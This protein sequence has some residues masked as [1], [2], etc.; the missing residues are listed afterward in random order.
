MEDRIEQIPQADWVDQDLLT[1]ELAGS[2]LDEEIAAER[3]RIDRVDRGIGGDDIVMSRA[4][5]ERRLAAM[6]AIRADNTQQA[7][8]RF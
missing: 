5:M 6:E 1:R 2:L 7:T 3:G 4:D 8:I